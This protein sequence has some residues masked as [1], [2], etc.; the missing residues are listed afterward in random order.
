MGLR[1]TAIGVLAAAGMAGCEV[2]NALKP[3]P[4]P[5]H[6]TAGTEEVDN[7][8]AEAA[9]KAAEA[10]KV[11]GE[12]PVESIAP[13]LLALIGKTMYVMPAATKNG[14]LNVRDV[15]VSKDGPASTVIGKIPVGKDVLVVAVG[16]EDWAHVIYE[17]ETGAKKPGW[18]AIRNGNPPAT[19][20]SLTK[21]EPKPVPAP[22]PKTPEVVTS[23]MYVEN[24]VTAF[25][26]LKLRDKPVDGKE[27]TRLSAG[28]EVTTEG[29]IEA[30][31]VKVKVDGREGYVAALY[32]GK[33]KPEAPKPTPA[34]VKPEAKEFAPVTQYVISSVT[35][36]GGLALREKGD[37]EGKE[38]KRLPAG[39][40][41]TQTGPVNADGYAKV[42]AGGVEGYVGAVYLAKDK[43]AE[44][45]VMPGWQKPEDKK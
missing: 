18:V 35:A 6:Q 8:A 37:K 41:V 22:A 44:V 29:P 24:N 19:Y 16:K 45:K 10:A 26:G 40:E 1:E 14:G 39:T 5:T 3:A 21:E 4:E 36:N 30:G 34:P 42:T 17:D 2:P 43:P 7:T 27:L 31:W 20:L 9:R 15:F 12:A 32:L 38:M 13:E 25:G 28:A 23:T 11:P 33:E